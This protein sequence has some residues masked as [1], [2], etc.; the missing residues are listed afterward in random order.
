MGTLQ[1]AVSL[2][3]IGFGFVIGGA[4][5]LLKSDTVSDADKERYKDL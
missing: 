1:I 3:V 4:Y 5:L 2:I